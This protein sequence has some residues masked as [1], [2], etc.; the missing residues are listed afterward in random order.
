MKPR[1]SRPSLPLLNLAFTFP[2]STHIGELL[3]LH[4]PF[5]YPTTLLFSSL[6][7]SG[8]IPRGFPGDQLGAF[9]LVKDLAGFMPV[10]SI[11]NLFRASIFFISSSD[12]L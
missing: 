4:Q 2:R 12:F 7:H 3:Y 8:V 9:F 6:H 1:S 10:E 5:G 11:E